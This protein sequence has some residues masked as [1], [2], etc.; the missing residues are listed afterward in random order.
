MNIDD[1][2]KFFCLIDPLRITAKY[3]EITFWEK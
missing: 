3:K 2:K 1:L